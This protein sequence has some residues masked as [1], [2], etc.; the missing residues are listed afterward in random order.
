MRSFLAVSEGFKKKVRRGLLVILGWP[1]HSCAVV[2]SFVLGRLDLD[3]VVPVKSW[4]S[5]CVGAIL[6]LRIRFLSQ[7]VC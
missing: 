2:P 4:G 6:L 5:S 3:H 1:G 7:L